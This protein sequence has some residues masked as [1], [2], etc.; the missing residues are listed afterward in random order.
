MSGEIRFRGL[1]KQN[2]DFAAFLRDFTAYKAIKDGGDWLIPSGDSALRRGPPQIVQ[3]Q[4]QVALKESEF[5]FAAKALVSHIS[6]S[7]DKFYRENPIKYKIEMDE[8]S[9]PNELHALLIDLT[10]AQPEEVESIVHSKLLPFM[11]DKF[12]SIAVTPVTVDADK[13]QAFAALPKFAFLMGKYD[14]E[15]VNELVF[16]RRALTGILPSAF[17]V[18]AY[19][20]ALTGQ[21]P[22]ALTLPVTRANCAWHF[23]GEGMWQFSHVQTEGPFQQFREN[24]NPVS[25]N[26]SVFGLPGL[27]NMNEANI[28]RFLRLV[29]TSI[30]KLM[31][32]LLDPR[33]FLDDSS[34]D[35]SFERQLQAL[36]V[37]HLIFADLM[38]MN[39]PTNS[40]HKI[41]YTMSVLDK[42]ANLMNS[43]GN[44]G[45]SEGKVFQDLVS[46]A[47]RERLQKIYSNADSVCGADLCKVLCDVAEVTYASIHQQYR[48]DLGKG[49]IDETTLAFRLRQHRNLRHGTFLGKDQFGELFAEARGYVPENT[50]TL[51]FLLVLA[52]AINPGEFLLPLDEAA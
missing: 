10:T 44:L 41:S 9:I 26:P 13:F 45:Q 17:D 35:V 28:W 12:K 48:E 3:T 18:L 33:N 5:E 4:G 21:V 42:I 34:G 16:S 40:Y 37:V 30:D 31:R 2:S 39:Y 38:A 47:Q 32:F 46:M 51:P 8:H 50:A 52:F 27:R 22:T 49:D 24:I 6:E 11:V 25:V 19:I 36:G 23:Q 43:L 14:L 29:A 15:T 7:H 1:A 20:N